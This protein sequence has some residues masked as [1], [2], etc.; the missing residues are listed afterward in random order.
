MTAFAPAIRSRAARW[1]ADALGPWHAFA[2]P[3]ARAPLSQRGLALGAALAVQLPLVSES[4]VLGFW[5]A[6][7]VGGGI[8]LMGLPQALGW[9]EA[10]LQRL[11]TLALVSGL[12]ALIVMTVIVTV[13]SVKIE[14]LR[15]A[16]AFSAM[17]AVVLP[18]GFVRVRLKAAILF[19]PLAITAWA[20]IT[21]FAGAALLLLGLTWPTSSGSDLG[22]QASVTM[23]VFVVTWIVSFAVNRFESTRGPRWAGRLLTLRNGLIGLGGV[24]FALVVARTS[25]PWLE[26]SAAR[27]AFNTPLEGIAPLAGLMAGALLS[28]GVAAVFFLLP[29]LFARLQLSGRSGA[30][31]VGEASW[32]VALGCLFAPLTMALLSIVNADDMSGGLDRL[33][34]YVTM[35]S[36]GILELGAIAYAVVRLLLG[37]PAGQSGTP[38]WVVLPGAGQ[39][40]HALAAAEATVRSWAEG[41]VTLLATP[42]LALS[43]LGP[44]LRLAREASLDAPFARSASDA[45][46]W[47]RD[48]PDEDR[49]TSLP[50]REIYAAAPAAT[51]LLAGLPQDA[52][53]LVLLEGPLAV[54]W[55]DALRALPSHSLRVASDEKFFPHGAQ[56]FGQQKGTD[57]R[58]CNFNDARDQEFLLASFMREHRPRSAGVRHLLIVHGA[59]D[60]AVAKRL[61]ALLDGQTDAAGRMIRSSTTFPLEQLGDL[62]SWTPQVWDS[63]FTLHLHALNKGERELPWVAKLWRTLLGGTRD[64]LPMRL[65]LAVLEDGFTPS[66]SK[67][68]SAPGRW[69][70]AVVSMRTAGS[71]GSRPLYAEAAYTAHLTLPPASALA[72]MLPMVAQAILEEAF[73]ASPLAPP[74]AVVEKGGHAVE[75]EAPPQPSA[76]AAI[77]NLPEHW[78]A[79]RMRVF[80]SH[81]HHESVI[82]I[83]RQ[84]C[85]ALEQRLGST[86]SVF[87]DQSEH[88]VAVERSRPVI[89]D[90]L[91]TATHFVLLASSDYW[92]SAWLRDL[93]EATSHHNVGGQPKLF[94]VF[95]DSTPESFK[96]YAFH[97]DFRFLGPFS[98]D[99][100][101][102]LISLNWQ[103]EATAVEGIDRVADRFASAAFT[104]PS[105][106]DGNRPIALNSVRE[107][108]E[109]AAML[110]RAL[111]LRGFE[112]EANIDLLDDEARQLYLSSML[113][114]LTGPAMNDYDRY[115]LRDPD[116]ALEFGKLVL[117]VLVAPVET[118]FA[119]RE[120]NA[121]NERYLSKLD[122]EALNE[123][124]E[125]VAEKIAGIASSTIGAS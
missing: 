79:A 33:S 23:A 37:R 99:E 110:S 54:G 44:H 32:V 35:D 94:C 105:L 2:A 97:I 98:V 89:D 20:A 90:A 114:V 73:L 123:E 15:M 83:A 68:S 124:I 95:A 72:G 103:D 75:G 3:L 47:R 42:A 86:A 120:N 66:E 31:A 61:A 18:Y 24:S 45:Q 115:T 8:A 26:V 80:I 111:K 38:L 25:V 91:G 67:S 53:V 71:E 46:N 107:Y 70:D 100:D 60:Q 11:G 119:L 7:L 13:D 28:V 19:G 1:A 58:V 74:A 82:F 108:A 118:T 30:S 84:L 39:S 16:M 116:I 56:L 62:L 17:G 102:R 27:A 77:T 55:G 81:S 109:H 63:A 43:L 96:N 87:F 22:I 51:A 85:D 12:L 104:V 36:L 59:T 117:P 88:A 92:L 49:R 10:A 5:V 93:E 101:R 113:V 41:P 9:S 21:L 69:A 4:V 121:L 34:S 64:Q 112:V 65:D 78:Y 57:W 14:Q 50:L 106:N 6:L 76:S 122:P 125:R 40:N 29:G 48:L 52:R